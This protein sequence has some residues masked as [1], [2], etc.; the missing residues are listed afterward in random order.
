V[1]AGL[2]F[3][4]M[5]TYLERAADQCSNIALLVLGKNNASIMNNYHNYISELHSTGNQDYLAEQ[6]NRRDQYIVP[7]QAIGE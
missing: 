2:V 3:M 6:K 5:L 4:D 7:L 1:D